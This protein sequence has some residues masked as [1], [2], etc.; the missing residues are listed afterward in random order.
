MVS[1]AWASIWPQEEGA[2][3]RAH[4]PLALTR[5]ARQRVVFGWPRLRV[6]RARPRQP[7]ARRCR[8]A[9]RRCRRPR[10]RPRSRR[11]LGPPTDIRDARKTSSL[12]IRLGGAPG[13]GRFRRRRGGRRWGRRAI[14]P[15]AASEEAE[16][17]GRGAGVRQGERREVFSGP[18]LLPPPAKQAKPAKLP[19]AAQVCND[20]VRSFFEATSAADK[21]ARVF[22]RPPGAAER[23]TPFEEARSGRSSSSSS[24]RTSAAAGEVT[25]RLLRARS[26]PTCFG[27]RRPRSTP[28]A[29]EVP[30][31]IGA[32]RATARVIRRSGA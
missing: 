5:G 13:A 14:A 16:A 31:R 27:G 18:S 20:F 15:T 26:R 21:H 1:S 4:P 19:A 24:P 30:R 2:A 32:T 28:S 7:F 17:A 9:P 10:R 12:L 22:T 3:P 6:R 23:G 11:G 25:S 29:H 8:H